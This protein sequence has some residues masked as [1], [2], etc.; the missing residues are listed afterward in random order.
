[1]DPNARNLE[2]QA[3]SLGIASRVTFLGW[4]PFDDVP[5]YLKAADCFGFASLTE[6]QGLVTLEAVAAGL[7]V[8][9]VAGHRHQRHRAP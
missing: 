5:C 1:M 7:P 4:L 6:T 2:K 3:Q 8:A 9:A